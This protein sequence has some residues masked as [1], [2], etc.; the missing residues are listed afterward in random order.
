MPTSTALS[1]TSAAAAP[2]SRCARQ[3]TRR[4]W[5]EEGVMTMIASSQ[6]SRRSFLASAAA[7]GGGLSLGF[8]IQFDIA[9]AQAADGPPEGDAWAVLPPDDT[10]VVR[11]ARCG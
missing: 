5:R 10:V 11:L 3:F 1:R 4:L 9:A 7:A 6:V 2:I 8:G